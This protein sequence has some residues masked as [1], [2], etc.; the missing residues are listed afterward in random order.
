MH[1]IILFHL[2]MKIETLNFAH[3]NVRD[4]LSCVRN[5]TAVAQLVQPHQTI[6]ITQ[7][8]NLRF[9]QRIVI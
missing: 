8:K 5:Y 3:F 9:K 1:D 6:T 2:M 4:C 7:L